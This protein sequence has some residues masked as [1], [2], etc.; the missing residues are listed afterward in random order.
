MQLHVRILDDNVNF[1]AKPCAQ[2]AMSVSSIKL[3]YLS[4]C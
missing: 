4:D 1:E 2:N 3:R